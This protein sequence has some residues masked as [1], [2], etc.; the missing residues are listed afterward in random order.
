MK[1]VYKLNVECGRM[2]ELE[3]VFVAEKEMVEALIE[4]KIVVNFGEALGKHSDIHC[5]INQDEITL[6]S[7]SPEVVAVILEHGLSSGFNPL[8]RYVYGCA[9]SV[10]DIIADATEDDWQVCDAVRLYIE[11]KGATSADL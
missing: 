11:R 8:H 7:E 1:G 9:G 10:P 2:G 5:P 6:V 4:S 3:G